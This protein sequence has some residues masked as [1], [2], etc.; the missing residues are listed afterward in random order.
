MK[1]MKWG[2]WEDPYDE[3]NEKDEDLCEYS[4]DEGE[5]ENPLDEENEK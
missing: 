1:E 2:R 3:G 5:L 4:W